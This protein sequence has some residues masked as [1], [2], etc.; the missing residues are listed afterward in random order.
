MD[1]AEAV[2][3]FDAEGEPA[4]HILSSADMKDDDDRQF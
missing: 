1:G 2:A 3:P 4:D